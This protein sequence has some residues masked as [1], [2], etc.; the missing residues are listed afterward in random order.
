MGTNNVVFLEVIEWFDESGKELVHRIPEQGSGEIKW[1]AQ[2]TVRESQAAGIMKRVCAAVISF[3]A[4]LLF[5]ILTFGDDSHYTNILVGDRA[6]ALAGAYTAISDDPSGMYYNPAGI[7]Y[8]TESNLSLSV[9]GYTSTSKK[10]KGAI[11]GRDWLRKSSGIV[12]NFFGMLYTW[13]K[14][15]MGLSYAVPDQITENQYDTL[16]DL[17]SGTPGLSVSKFMI[18]HKTEDKTYHFGPSF[19]VEMT[20]HLS[21]GVTLYVHYRYTDYISNQMA[22]LS[23]SQTNWFNHYMNSEEWGVRPILGLMW[24]QPSKFSVGLAVSRVFALRS[25]SRLQMTEKD[26]ND[27]ITILDPPN[28]SDTRNYPYKISFGAAFFPSPSLL[29]TADVTYY[30]P[31]DYVLFGTKQSFDAVVNGSHWQIEHGCPQATRMTASLRPPSTRS[32]SLAEAVEGIIVI[33]AQ[34]SADKRKLYPKL[35]GLRVALEESRLEYHP[36]VQ[37]HGEFIHASLRTA[38]DRTSLTYGVR[39]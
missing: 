17:P 16:F 32:L 14:L 1:G 4:V 34:M 27:K 35:A 33:L 15:K 38:L 28:S 26:V 19:A 23:N 11:G 5:P 18:N 22:W 39:M 37:N 25:E 13:G 36:F 12:P 21:I 31:T 10:Y 8:A 9:N 6:G 29:I 20:P 7:A 2:M 30:M 3:I 24:R